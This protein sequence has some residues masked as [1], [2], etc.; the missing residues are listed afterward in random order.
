M[1]KLASLLDTS[2]IV[3]AVAEPAIR[4]GHLRPL[5]LLRELEQ[6]ILL[7]ARLL[8][9]AATHHGNREVMEFLQSAAGGGP[10]PGRKKCPPPPRAMAT[11][12]C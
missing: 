2:V 8:V 3:A 1:N 5:V 12:L 10:T 11:T 6:S 4:R 9:L 7:P